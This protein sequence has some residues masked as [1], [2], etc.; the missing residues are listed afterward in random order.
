[1]KQIGNLKSLDSLEKTRTGADK[2]IQT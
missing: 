1:L 2:F